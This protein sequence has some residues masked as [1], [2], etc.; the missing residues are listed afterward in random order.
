MPS[1]MRSLKLRDGGLSPMFRT[2]TQLIQLRL[3]SYY[4]LGEPV[5]PRND[6][7]AAPHIIF[8]L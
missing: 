1:S 3:H 5:R 6:S 8:S 2:L 7:S 4:T